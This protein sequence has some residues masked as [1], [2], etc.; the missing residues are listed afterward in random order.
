M[1][2][3]NSLRKM[4]GVL[5]L[6]STLVFSSSAYICTEHPKK[7]T[8]VKG[9]TTILPCESDLDSES[10]TFNWT[11]DGNTIES[12]LRYKMQ[13]DLFWI[14]NTTSSDSGLYV[15]RSTNSTGITMHGSMESQVLVSIEAG[16]C[17]SIPDIKLTLEG[18]NITLNCSE[19][20]IPVLGQRLQ[21]E[22][23]KDCEPTDLRGSEITLFNVNMNNT[24]NYTCLVIFRYEDKNYTASHTFQLT[25]LRKG[26]E[27]KLECNVLIG[28]GEEL[29]FETSVYWLIN[30]SFVET[31]PE[32]QQ[33]LTTYTNDSWMFGNSTLFISKVLPEFF[34]V[35]FT[36]V[37]LNPMGNDMGQVWLSQADNTNHTLLITVM[38]IILTV[39]VGAV[40]LSFF[41]IDLTLAYRHVCCK[42]KASKETRLYDA[43]VLYLHAKS[44]GSSTAQEL[45]LRTIPEILEK[46][47]NLKL[48][49]HG[50]DHDT[51]G[52]VTDV[53]SQ[54]KAVILILPG[55][56]KEKNLLPISQDENRLEDSQ[57]SELFSDITHSGVPLLL[58][59]SGENADYS[60]LPESIQSI[61]K[62]DR[63]LKWK[64][65]VQPNGRF[66]KQLR[67]HMT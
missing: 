66:W 10:S 44:P 9:Q 7:I 51:E 26:V 65:T 23:K 37:I 1:L 67:Y 21:V 14:L 58:V 60:L 6:L 57:L 28:F 15:C 61:I 24:G 2:L 27:T 11:K 12:S 17:P 42:D 41:K 49:I 36:C 20:L 55:N 35:P 8:T 46:R 62:K 59:E 5:I 40:L 43:Y 64:P 45:A 16:P 29:K 18:T 25:V 63:V 52:S 31:H 47:H 13:G 39:I 38:L 34:G 54:S 19:D 53:L 22:W 30:E 48:F 50:R 3:L 4:P 33:N 32:L 56:N